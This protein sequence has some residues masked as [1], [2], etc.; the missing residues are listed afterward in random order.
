[1]IVPREVNRVKVCRT[2]TVCKLRYKEGHSHRARVKNLIAPLHYDQ[3]MLAVPDE[4]VQQVRQALEHLRGKQNPVVKF[5]AYTD[6]IP[7]K[8]RDERIYGDPVGLSKAVARRVALAVQDNLGLPNAAIES[9]G[10]GAS[11]PV[12]SNDTQQGRALNRRVEVEFW[13]DDPLQDLPDEP[14]PCPDAPGAETVTRV[15]DSASGSIDPILFANGKPVIPA[16]YPDTLR[17]IMGEIRDKDHVRLRFV[18]YTG[19]KRLDR[20]TAAV[21]GDDIGLSMARARRTMAALSEQMGLTEGQAEFDG[22]GYVQSDDVVNAGFIESDTSRVEVKVVYDEPIIRDDYEGVEVTPL[23]REVHPVDPFALNLMRITVDGKPLDDPGK[24]SSDV[25]RCTD[26][27]LEKAQIQFKHDSLKL[28]P[29]LNMTAWPRTIRY[30]DLPDTAFVENLVHFRLYTNYRS[31]IERA[32]VR[33]FKEEQSVRDTPVAVIAM[34]ADGMAQWQPEFESFSASV[35]KLQYL[36]RVYDKNGLFDETTPQPLWVADQIDPS[37]AEAKLREELLVGY[38]ETRIASRNIPLRGGTVEAHGTAIPEAHGV[39]MAG[40][41]VPVDGKGS[42]VAEEILPEGMHTVEVAVLDKSGNGELFLRDLELKKSD[43]FTVGI[44]DLTLS[45]NKTNGPAKLLAP[46]KPQ[47]SDDIDLQGRLA[48]YTT[49]KFEN[50]WSLTASADTREGPLDEIFSN[51]MD[52]SPDALFRRIDPDYHYPTFGDDSTV[53]EDAPTSGKFYIRAKKDQTYGLWGNFK[54]G[55]TDNDLAHVDRG[56]YGA[57]LHYQP[58]DTTSFGEPRLLVD[59]FAADPG[60]VAERDEFQGT[61][62]SLYYLRVQDVLQGSERVRIEVRDKDS[63]IVLAVK[64]LVPGL[65]YD[66]DYLQ[67]RILLTQPLPATADDGLLVHTGSISGNPVYLVARYEFTPGFDDPNTLAAGGRVHYWF[68]DYVKVGLTANR[69]KAEGIENNLG[70][71]DLTL[72][73]SAESWV[74]VETGR[75]KGPGQLTTTAPDGG[76]NFSTPDSFDDSTSEASAYRVDA[77]IG[78]K[79]FFENGRGRVTFYLQDLEAGYSAPGL[80]TARDL[81]QYGGKGELPV[82]DRLGV[83]LKIDKQDQSEGLETKAGEL[84]LDYRMGENWTLSSGVRHDSRKDNSAVVPATQEEGDRTDA[85]AKL[86]Y[87][88]HAQWTTYGFVQETLRT[89]G[90]REDNA[91]IG[92]GGSLRLT[93]QFNVVGEVSGGDLGLGAKLGTEYLYSDRSTVYLNYTLENDERTDNGLRARKGTMTSGFRKRY[94]DSASVYLEERYTHGDVPTGLMH[95]T[96]VDLAPFDHFNFGAHLD[97][98][99]LQDHD[100]A[101]ETERKALAVS[102]GYGFDKVKIASAVEYREDNIEQPDTSS[103]KRTTWLLKN[104]LK[105]QLSPDMRLLGKV[106]YSVSDSSQGKSYDADYTEAVLGLAYRPVYHDRLNALLKYTY[107]Y[108]VP[109]PDQVTGTN[110]AVDFIQRSNIASLDIMYDLTSRWTVGA[111]YAYRLGQVAPDREHR[112]FFDSRAH[113][114]VLRA[115]WQFLY[116]WDALFEV[117]RLDL[118]D[119]ED[120]R[121]GVLMGIYRHLGNH[122][123][124]GVGYN[125]SDFSDDLT[126]LDYKHQGLFI[127]L[128]GTL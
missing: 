83:R 110:T 68:N 91:R 73:K 29:R 8:G 104:N 19:N 94:S 93:D 63:G 4:F 117:R 33:I 84:G 37:V 61:D 35:N 101:A 78:V 5:I 54:I 49:G 56:L 112:E 50:G 90:N 45:A 118:P 51:F 58:L 98:G 12:A 111:K 127:N 1:M 123:K 74:R 17:R 99:T 9:D 21:Y 27:A 6:N 89:S 18:G 15:Y 100:T 2:E 115:D 88:S 77:S 108:N 66:I 79:D 23:T 31:F 86:L 70:G 30:Q 97:F 96:G 26:V 109:S 34:D 59:G 120:S 80:A 36:V 47:Y 28:E 114:Y 25:Q 53:A 16:G 39:W 13:H 11:R 32:E 82:T 60:T 81:T 7:L 71:A 20:R 119:A 121:S 122:I 44:A 48:F 95:S 124:V 38:G 40:N 87:D 126:E 57:N 106:N 22:R 42:F 107:F 102:A 76:F 55:Y 92:T 3:G 41:E 72:R 69:D 75:T 125:F 103:T 113:L 43:R 10:R 105:Y 62:G 64:N 65:D 46:D 116:N 85:V 67:G 14:Q 128:I 24:C 52:K